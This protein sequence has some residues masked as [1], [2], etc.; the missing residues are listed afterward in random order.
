MVLKIL[1][2]C[3]SVEGSSVRA[4][5]YRLKLLHI[6]ATLQLEH[7]GSSEAAASLLATAQSIPASSSTA[8]PLQSSLR[9][10]LQSLVG[11]KTEVLHTGVETL[12]GWTIGKR[13]M[14]FKSV[15]HK[16]SHC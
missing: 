4:D 2:S 15:Y 13:S 10:A 3:V 8:S 1:F 7:P 9:G 14:G 5:N 6:A 11:G 16:Q 12:Y